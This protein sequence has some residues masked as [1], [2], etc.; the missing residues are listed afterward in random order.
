MKKSLSGGP[1]NAHLL[2]GVTRAKGVSG[3]KMGPRRKSKGYKA[4]LPKGK[5]LG[6]QK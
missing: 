3:M 6:P 2:S 4:S 1:G 5:P